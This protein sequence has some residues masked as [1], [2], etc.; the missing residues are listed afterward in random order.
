MEQRRRP[1]KGLPNF[2]YRN[3]EEELRDAR[4]S[5]YRWWFEFL[6][7]NKT[8]WLLCKTN[9]RT[10]DSNLARL[11]RAFGDVHEMEFDQW[12]LRHGCHVFAEQ[13]DPP[14]VK[15]IEPDY[16]NLKEPSKDRVLIEV[17]L[18]LRKETVQKQ[19]RRI[20]AS[21][22]FERPRNVL[23]TST[24]DYKI[25]PVAVRLNV[26][27][28]T[29][30]VWCAHR[31]MILKPQLAGDAEVQTAE[32]GRCDLFELGKLLKL[33]PANARL[34]DD[35]DEQKRRQNRMRA[36]VSRYIRRANQLILCVEYGSFPLFKTR[37]PSKDRRFT[38]THLAA[39]K[40]LE[41]EWWA[42]EFKT[43]TIT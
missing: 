34:S 39:H 11:W 29:H 8:Y 23:A 25:H 10:I 17:P 26:L 30:E 12:W 9:G 21:I 42:M 40:A 22:D 36:T 2:R 1:Q 6:R 37:L 41:D 32:R 38:L 14:K 24:A 43:P 20:L 16:A 27:Q 13:I 31:E 4:S 33:S 28:K 19:L 15:L 35:Y 3:E 7:L 18:I 5:V